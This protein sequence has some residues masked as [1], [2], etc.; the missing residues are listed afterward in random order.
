MKNVQVKLK[1]M[2]IHD[3]GANE[4]GLMIWRMVKDTC[5]QQITRAN[6]YTK[7]RV[8]VL[9]AKASGGGVTTV[10]SSTFASRDKLNV[11]T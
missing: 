7:V 8:E 11:V 9:G 6:P 2:Y 4:S 5:C 1:S 3:P 10:C